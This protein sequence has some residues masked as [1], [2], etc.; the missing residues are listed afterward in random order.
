M[1][2]VYLAID[3]ANGDRQ[4]ALKRVRKDRVDQ[5]ALAILRNEFLSLVP[6]NHPNLAR[7]YDFG[8]D[9]E[10]GDLFFTSEYANGIS[11]LKAVQPLHLGKPNGFE[12]FVNLL[13]QVLRGLEFIHCRAL[14][15]G[16][17]KPENVLVTTFTRKTDPPT[18]EMRVKIIDFGLATR[19]KTRGGKKILG[20]PHY[21]APETILG[22]EIDRRTDLYS[23]GVVLYHLTTGRPPFRGSSNLEVLKS[24]LEQTPPPPHE[25]NSKVPKTLGKIILRLMEKQPSDR[26]QTALEV[27]EKISADFGLDIPLETAATSNSYLETSVLVGRETEAA[28]LRAAFLAA[29]TMEEI[30]EDPDE[31]PEL[32]APRKEPGPVRTGTEVLPAGQTLIVRGEKGLGKRRLAEGL[33]HIAQTR[34]ANFLPVEC[35]RR[36]R[37]GGKSLEHLMNQLADTQ[38]R[39]GDDL[40]SGNVQGAMALMRQLQ[41]CT[42]EPISGYGS[43][44]DEVALRLLAASRSRSLLLHFHDLHLAGKPIVKL[45]E[46]M[47]R[48]LVEGRVAGTR[49]L[50]TATALDRGEVEGSDFQR[51]CNTKLYRKSVQELKLKRLS[52]A[53]VGRLIQDA[54]VGFEFDNAFVKRVLEESDGNPEV[55]L[56]ILK[57]FL[58]RQKMTRT[59]RG[60]VISSDYENEDVPGKVRRELKERMAGLT[61]DALRLATAFAVM[62]ES[63]ELDMAARLAG[64]APRSTLRSLELL[65]REKILQ[66]SSGGSRQN[67]YSF[68]HL[69]ARVILYGLIPPSGLAAMHERAGVICEAIY[70]HSG[71]ESVKNLAYHFLKAENYEN[72]TRYGLQAAR[73]L[74]RELAPLQAIETYQKV[75]ELAGADNSDLVS[76]VH[77]E[78]ASL[79]FQMGDY[80]GVL[81]FRDALGSSHEEEPLSTEETHMYIEAARAHARLGQFQKSV[82][83]LNRVARLHVDRGP[84]GHLASMMLALSELHFYKGNFVESL[85]WCTRVLDSQEKIKDPW[86]LSQIYM[87]L[88]ENHALLNNS[89]SA[90][91]Y[92][93]LALRLI[94]TQHDTRHLAWS[95]FC[96]GKYYTYEHQFSKAL[97]QFQLCLLLR[98]K[99]NELDGQADCLKELGTLHHLM[100]N[101]EEARQHLEEARALYERS[102]NL[103]RSVSTLCT[104]GEVCGLLGDYDKCDEFVGEALR[105]M[106]PLEKKRLTMETLLT[107]A[108]TC[109]DRGELTK[110]GR[111]LDE[112]ERLRSP[113]VGTGAGAVRLLALLSDLAFHSGRI[114]DALEHTR[115]GVLVAREIKDP[116]ALAEIVTRQ[117]YLYCRMG[118]TG[119]ARHHL[120]TLFETAKHHGLHAGEGWA[121]LLEG[122]MFAN[123]NKLDS[124]EK[125]FSQA[126]DLLTSQG[127]ARDL[128]HLHLEHGVLHLEMGNHEQAYLNFEEGLFLAEKLQLSYMRCRYY[129]A[130]GLLEAA[131][132]EGQPSRSERYFLLSEELA[133]QAPY[134][135]ILWQVRHHLGRLFH[136][137]GRLSEAANY[138]K[139][140][141]LELVAVLQEIPSVRRRSYRQV[142]GADDLES[143]IEMATELSL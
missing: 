125:R 99:M 140:S 117:S 78:I 46:R 5:R 1:G 119:D 112:A 134:P 57:F 120:A 28:K 133:M 18:S 54:F 139:N 83:L 47:N 105:R 9:N 142:T 113:R 60:W 77:R 11:W 106:K 16:D 64:T 13:T 43:V 126:S 95:L 76:S 34:G 44:I 115:G 94:E 132:P 90:V 10:T 124:A 24:H 14:V 53:E 70:R 8:V 118:S 135:E 103:S 52:E 116:V 25:Q 123:E 4:V 2:A 38:D 3:T 84:T 92:C 41:E 58:D 36:S 75:L 69:S 131:I 93:Q 26:F 80:R 86:L 40:D 108:R 39:H 89:D 65:R 51:L 121:R 19:Q 17:I 21:I 12:K 107:T 97:K 22:S 79:R 6:L 31:E 122:M 114:S 50:I 85:R 91:G 68:V 138:L 128:V 49:F 88:A 55:V 100:G 45:M 20:T 130:M 59:T 42:D 111:Y 29:C 127:S 23:L 62:G 141:K 82:E 136:Q 37:D 129:F 87:L 102:G 56:D 48:F 98:R 15:H 72:G 63:C 109:I 101:K 104:L 73:E 7:A 32:T 96:R 137:T 81:Q 66:A 67:E 30:Q 110:A 74:A 61:G 143:M 71:K 35:G 33:R 27:I